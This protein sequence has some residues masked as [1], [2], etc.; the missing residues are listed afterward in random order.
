[1]ILT[2]NQKSLTLSAIDEVAKGIH[3][4][5]TELLWRYSEELRH[6][7]SG[8]VLEKAPPGYIK[9]YVNDSLQRLF[10]TL[11]LL[12]R[13]SEVQVLELGAN[14][15]LLSILHDMFFDHDVSYANFFDE[16]IFSTEI[17]E[18]C[19]KMWNDEFE[20]KYEFRFKTFNVELVTWP[21]ADE[22]FDMVLCCEVLEHLILDPFRIFQEAR[23]VLRPGG[24]LL[25]TTPNAVRLTNFAHMLDGNNFFGIYH[26]QSGRV[27]GRHNREFTVEEI[28]F[29]LARYGYEVLKLETEDLFD[30]DRIEIASAT[31]EGVKR[32][33]RKK[34]QLERILHEVGAASKNRG[35][36]IYALAKKPTSNFDGVDAH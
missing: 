20:K 14:P 30:Y 5:H 13:Q 32:S 24:T 2:P 18:S 36:T 22:S 10:K 21:Y 7:L 33:P 34:A 6:Y 11:T 28:A 15:Y 23:R 8:F 27:Y 35:D 12:P 9:T 16:R 4:G 29:L 19:Q 31:V 1:M 26:P 25:L 17:G 3:A